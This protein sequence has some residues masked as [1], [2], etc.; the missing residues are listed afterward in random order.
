VNISR[1]LLIVAAWLAATVCLGIALRHADLVALRQVVA[2]ARPAGLLLAVTLNAGLLMLWTTAWLALLPRSAPP[3]SFGVLF[4][5]NALTLALA[6]T[7]PFLGGH[8]SGIALLAKR[9]RLGAGNA[10]SLMVL[11]QW[12]EGLSKVTLYLIAGSLAPLPSW[13]RPAVLSVCVGVAVLSLILLIVRR[14]WESMS[15][16]RSPS[17][18]AVAFACFVGM[19]ALEGLAIVA[20]QRAFGVAVTPAGTLLILTFV[21]LATMLPLAPGNVGPYELA[22]AAGYRYLGVPQDTALAL[23]LAQHAC[24]LTPAV[25]VGYAMLSARAIADVYT[26]RWAGSTDDQSARGVVSRLFAAMRSRSA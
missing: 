3:T 10:V 19:K 23:A 5:I 9:A 13:L 4:E 12:G 1:R 7:L 11:D 15:A 6:N 16:L 20:V 17:H 24:F 25:G 21:S 26:S 2:T 22:A 14:R 8:A 18:A